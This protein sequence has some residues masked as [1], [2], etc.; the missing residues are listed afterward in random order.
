MAKEKSLVDKR[1]KLP[2]QYREKKLLKTPEN[3]GSC[4]ADF[5]FNIKGDIA[6]EKRVKPAKVF[7]DYKPPDSLRTK[8]KK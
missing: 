5:Q 3:N 2:K 1:Q 8:T 7:S 4:N 6:R